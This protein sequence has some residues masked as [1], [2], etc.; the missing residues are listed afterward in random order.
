MEKKKLRRILVW[1]TVF[2]STSYL[3]FGMIP[4][5]QGKAVFVDQPRSYYNSTNNGYYRLIVEPHE[6][7]TFY[8]D[9]YALNGVHS[10]ARLFSRAFKTVGIC[11]SSD[12]INTISIG[13]FAEHGGSYYVTYPYT[14][15]SDSLHNG[16]CFNNSILRKN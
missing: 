16:S 5:F 4:L 13:F 14:F 7:Y 1:L 12:D 10:E 11:R 2:L 15:N 3:I 6:Y 9:Y 8:L